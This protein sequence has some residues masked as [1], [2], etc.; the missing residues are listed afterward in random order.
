MISQDTCH[1]CH[2]NCTRRQVG[3]KKGD[4]QLKYSATHM[5]EPMARK[6][7]V[8]NRMGRPSRNASAVIA[9]VAFSG[10]CRCPLMAPHTRNRGTPP[11]RENAHSILDSHEKVR[12]PARK[13]PVP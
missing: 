2:E 9:Q 12:R 1:C 3:R 8:E 13:Y 11:S 5:M 6:A 7:V 4:S 10:V